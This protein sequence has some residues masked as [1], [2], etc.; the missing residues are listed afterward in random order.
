MPDATVRLPDR[1]LHQHPRTATGLVLAAVCLTASVAVVLAYQP[2]IARQH[3]HVEQH[4]QE[5]ARRVDA[6]LSLRFATLHQQTRNLTVLAES[7]HAPLTEA[8][9]LLKRLL[10]VS[11]VDSIYGM[12]LWY[13]A[14][15]DHRLPIES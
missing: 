10:S 7:L 6:E 5:L 1:L 13:A 8:E 11:P 12:G 3:Q 4:R 15:A 9:P 14:G 2:E